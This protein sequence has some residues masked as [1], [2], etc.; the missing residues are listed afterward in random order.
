VTNSEFPFVGVFTTGTPPIIA[1][2][3][4]GENPSYA[5]LIFCAVVEVLN[6][7]FDP[8]ALNGKIK[9]EVNTK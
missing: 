5:V 3:S 6:R 4:T 7:S 8:E 1:S 2:S 9:E